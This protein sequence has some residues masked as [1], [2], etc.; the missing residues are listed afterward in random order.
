MNS[1][2]YRVTVEQVADERGQAVDGRSLVFEAACH[3]ELLGLVERVRAK[4][5]VATANGSAAMMV[6]LKLFGEIALAERK[7]PMFAE[8]HA[9]LG[10][11]IRA[12]KAAPDAAA[13]GGLRDAVE[14]DAVGAE[15]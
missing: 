1:Y 3:D 4:R 8:V 12:L 6:G 7:S 15:V 5:I 13:A 11:F 14:G 2:R 9:A 10:N